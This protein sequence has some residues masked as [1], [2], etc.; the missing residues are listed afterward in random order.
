VRPIEKLAEVL[1]TMQEQAG[2]RQQGRM[3]R[4]E[5]HVIRF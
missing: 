3:T 2:Q 1:D 4:F 5:G